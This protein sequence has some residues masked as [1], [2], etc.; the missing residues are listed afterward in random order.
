MNQPFSEVTRLVEAGEEDGAVA[1]AFD[2]AYLLIIQRRWPELDGA[3]R[4]WPAGHQPA[5]L[6]ALATATRPSLVRQHLP[7]R[8]DFLARAGLG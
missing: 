7:S 3:L 5:V 2:E 4:Q 6:L 1:A 8:E